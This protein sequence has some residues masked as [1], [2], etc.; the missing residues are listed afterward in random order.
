MKRTLIILG[1]ALAVT[2]GASA[3]FRFDGK[4]QAADYINNGGAVFAVDYKDTNGTDIVGGTL[5]LATVCRANVNCE[6]TT[7]AEYDQYLYFGHP[8]GFHDTSYQ[9][10]TPQFNETN[11][12]YL[13][14]WEGTSSIN[15]HK[16]LKNR[17]SSEFFKFNLTADDGA[18]GVTFSVKTDFKLDQG[19][20][21]NNN[22]NKNELT[23][24]NGTASTEIWGNGSNAPVESSATK[25]G[26]T[27]TFSYLSTMDYNAK[28]LDGDD[29]TLGTFWDHSPETEDCGDE[30]SSAEACYQLAD[31]AENRIVS[32]ANYDGDDNST[33][34]ELIDW[35][36]ET[37]VEI[38]LDRDGELFFGDLASITAASF[39]NGQGRVSLAALHASKP[40]ESINCPGSGGNSADDYDAATLLHCVTINSPET[41]TIPEPGSIALTA[42]ALG[43]L[44]RTRKIKKKMLLG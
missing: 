40:K 10:T 44:V 43:V 2:Q 18:N 4:F 37:G 16:D 8:K 35:V 30:A 3:A 7:T 34:V 42:L 38:K 27:T 32:Y 20:N 15:G 13:V 22:K 31:T 26:V 19:K 23:I 29:D 17:W 21:E 12:E 5:A 24:D 36:F 39:E 33:N 25:D 28:M 11:S 6:D 14:G 41:A 1:L 9:T